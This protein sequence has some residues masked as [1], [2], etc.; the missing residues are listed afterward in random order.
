VE[1]RVYLIRRIILLFF[2]LIGVTFLVFVIAMMIPKDAAFLW[3]GGTQGVTEQQLE[4]VRR[5]YHLND[6][7]YMQYWWY[8]SNI[9][10]GNLGVS[11]VRDVPVA[12]E[13]AAYLPNSLE[14]G[15]FSLVLSIIFGI[16]IGI[17]SATR[18]DTVADHASRLGALSMVSLPNFWV[19]LVF[20]LVFYY[21]LG[22]A[23]DPGGN[24]NQV[25]LFQHPLHTITGFNTLDALLTGNWPILYSLLQ[26]MAMP[27]LILGFYP[28]AMIAR[29]TRASMLETMS[30]DFI[31]TARA[32]GLP[33][34]IV[35]YKYALKNAVIPTTTT[36]GLSVGWL[37][38]GSVVVESIFYWPGIGR[39]AVDA[40]Q[41]FDFP[42]VIGYVLV[43][44][45]I[46]ATANLV[47]DVLYG[48][49][50]PRI[51]QG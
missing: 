37:L 39:Y 14:L 20:Q 6:P 21:Y 49:L 35:V 50:D 2:V 44:S 43:A 29:I 40:I 15:V 47:V 34:R 13:L 7:W 22:W 3:A 18:R 51:K 16:G 19:G 1:F 31:R 24:V 30:Q 36:I 17:I 12:T 33:E 25:L 32:Y 26:H 5:S 23:P 11:P 27:G 38:T 41:N 4:A 8:L 48:F 9:L 42:S 28:I 10:Q 46:F 45:I